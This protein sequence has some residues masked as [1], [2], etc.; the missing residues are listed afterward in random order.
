MCHT[1]GVRPTPPVAPGLRIKVF[2]L[3]CPIRA[4]VRGTT[5]VPAIPRSAPR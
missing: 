2:M 5:A 3:N 1:G 4:A